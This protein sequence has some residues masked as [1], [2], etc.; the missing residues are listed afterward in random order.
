MP[1]SIGSRNAFIKVTF[2]ITTPSITCKFTNQ[3]KKS[4]KFYK[5]EYGLVTDDCMDL[6]FDMEG[7]LSNSNSLTLQ[8]QLAT[9]EICFVVKASSGSKTAIVEGIHKPCKYIYSQ[10][11]SYN[12]I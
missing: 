1:L 10:I 5:I 8:L 12:K 2:D 6:P 3:P 11:P 9:S 7:Y 4:K